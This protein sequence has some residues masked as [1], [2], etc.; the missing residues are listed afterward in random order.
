[1]NRRLHW[2]LF[3]K[4]RS[5]LLLKVGLYSGDFFGLFCMNLWKVIFG[6]F[7]LINWNFFF[8]P[9]SSMIWGI[10]MQHFIEVPR[11]SHSIA[12][13][14][15]PGT[16]VGRLFK[17]PAQKRRWGV[18]GG[19]VGGR[20][21]TSKGVSNQ[22]GPFLNFPPPIFSST[23]WVDGW[24]K[25]NGEETIQDRYKKDVKD[26]WTCCQPKNTKRKGQINKDAWLKRLYSNASL[27]CWVICVMLNWCLC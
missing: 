11:L 19:G 15:S 27:L 2:V 26:C 4:F 10:K 12:L 21:L 25:P 1:M 18:G 22:V 16:E 14:L 20:W 17:L 24:N 6:S 5:S 3:L 23:N 9:S 8:P 13:F 7:L